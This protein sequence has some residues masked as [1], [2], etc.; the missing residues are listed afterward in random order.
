MGLF[1]IFLSKEQKEF[2]AIVKRMQDCIQKKD[3]ESAKSIYKELENT[4]KA[5]KASRKV[6]DD[7][8]ENFNICLWSYKRFLKI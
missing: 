4:V 3:L 8:I 1:D 2:N 5:F 6:D 7:I